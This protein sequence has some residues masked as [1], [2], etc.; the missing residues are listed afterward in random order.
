MDAHVPITAP[1]LRTLSPSPHASPMLGPA[2]PSAGGRSVSMASTASM[3]S[4]GSSGSRASDTSAARRRGYA[5]PQATTF[6]DSARNRESVM[7]LGTIA[8]L[9]YYFAR[10]GLLDGK[11]GQLYRDKSKDERKKVAGE[12][13]GPVISMPSLRQPKLRSGSD[14]TYS[15]MRSSP[16][17]AQ[18]LEPETSLDGA[19]MDSPIQ[20]EFAAHDHE[21]TSPMLP[22]TV[23]TYNFRAKPLPRPPT[24]PQMR[25]DVRDALADASKVLQEA[26]VETRESPSLPGPKE[27]GA[28]AEAVGSPDATEPQGWHEIQGMHILDLMTLAIRAAK[29][30]YTAHEHPARLAAL[31]SERRIREE[32]LTVMDTLK[33]MAS[34]TFHGGIR[35]E[36]RQVMQ[37]WIDDVEALLRQE[38]GQ[39][40]REA[41]ER[42][43]WAWMVESWSGRPREREWSFI[44]SFDPSTAPLPAW[45][46]PEEA[47]PL[48]TPF[49]QAL[50]SG[51]RLIQLH[52][53][54]VTKSKRPFGQIPT[55]HTDTIK[56]YRAAENLRFWIKA[57]ELRWEIV[58]RIDVLGVVYGRSAET[59]THFDRELM[60]WSAK[61]RE[62]FIREWRDHNSSTA[63]D[64]VPSR[65]PEDRALAVKVEAESLDLEH[66]PWHE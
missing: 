45:D 38:E 39:E 49:L 11:G 21:T 36:E 43:Q 32:L 51:I 26:E 18:P 25:R 44:R 20:E 47:S 30:Y 60:R 5:R 37:G 56:P 59:W 16:D 24:M 12:P 33:R 41:H 31:K 3:S 4:R 34:R 28:T 10:T 63:L 14:S 64:D 57:A 66:H 54:M 55:F 29:I 58:L 40:Q 17:P 6:A 61:V 23:S 7:S 27:A 50:Q 13:T 62:E 35:A 46:G 1:T 42:E 48:P 22:P 19:L 8:H 65:A 52:N 53:H 9:Q 15:S 2:R